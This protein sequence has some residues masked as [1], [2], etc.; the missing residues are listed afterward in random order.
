MIY[1]LLSTYN[2][3]TYLRPLLDS[4][5]AQSVLAWRLF[6]R[7]DNS[8]D[9]TLA[10]IKKYKNKLG[11]KLQVLEDDLGNIGATKSF[12][13]LIKSVPKDAE[14]IALCDQDDF[15]LETKLE[16]AINKFVDSQ[17][18]L[19]CSSTYITDEKL[20]V[21][22]KKNINIGGKINYKTAI[23][24]NYTSGCTYVFNKQLLKILKLNEYDFCNIIMHDYWIYLIACNL[25]KIYY[26]TNAYIY[27]RQHSNNYCGVGSRVNFLNYINNLSNFKKRCNVF[28]GNYKMV[29]KFQKIFKNSLSEEK[30]IYIEQFLASRETML[31]RVQ[32][33][34]KHIL[35]KQVGRKLFTYLMCKDEE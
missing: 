30:D 27:Y 35:Y 12:L 14:Y 3:Q 23:F 15:W 24:Q 21:L 10:I 31:K 5:L 9:Q 11:E 28:I 29:D 8:S 7:D 19:Y 26:D 16:N 22:Y 32:F 34:L 25:G 1:I 33:I 2:G 6:I 4:I 17:P 18:T 13:E 20:E